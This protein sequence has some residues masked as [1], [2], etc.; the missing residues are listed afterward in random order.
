MFIGYMSQVSL[1][2]DKCRS[3]SVSKGFSYGALPSKQFQ[4]MFVLKL[5]KI[6]LPFVPVCLTFVINKLLTPFHYQ[7]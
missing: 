4:R 7:M 5:H 2:V 6:A 3:S 1:N